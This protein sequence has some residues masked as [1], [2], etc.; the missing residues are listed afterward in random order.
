MSE[1]INNLAEK[2]SIKWLKF[3]N[4][5]KRK[6]LAMFDFTKS[7]WSVFVKRKLLFAVILSGRIFASI[8]VTLLP[9]LIGD[10]AIESM[11]LS[12][13]T[14]LFFIGF[15]VEAWRY[16]TVVLCSRF[17]AGIISGLRYSAYKFFLT[18]DPVYH[19]E[20]LPMNQQ[21]S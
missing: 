20:R 8:F 9:I 13:F 5:G 10:Y 2:F 3:T 1:Y 6:Y 14:Y 15:T 16:Y 11:K 21:T 17:I 7:W 12:S 18:V 19:S 4:L